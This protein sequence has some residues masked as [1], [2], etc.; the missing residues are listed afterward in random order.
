MDWLISYT[1]IG[2]FLSLR[3]VVSVRV[4]SRTLIFLYSLGRELSSHMKKLVHCL[5]QHEDT[6]QNTP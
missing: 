2:G 1:L 6:T 5:P 3:G 4:S